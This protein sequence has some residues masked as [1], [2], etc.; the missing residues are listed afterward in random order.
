MICLQ[1]LLALHQRATEESNA[2]RQL[3]MLTLCETHPTIITNVALSSDYEMPFWEGPRS[4]ARTILKRFL[5][6]DAEATLQCLN[7]LCRG[8]RDLAR[9]FTS[10]SSAPSASSI[11]ACSPLPRGVVIHTKLWESVYDLLNSKHMDGI[12]LVLQ[13]VARIAHVD[14][15]RADADEGF[16][17][18][19][20]RADQGLRSRFVRCV[21]SV[22]DALGT[23][24]DSFGAH[25]ESFAE[26][27][28]ASL[29][30]EFLGRE[31]M[32]EEIIQLMLCPVDSLNGAAK[33]LAL[34][35]YDT[36][37]RST[38]Y[39][40][41]LEH[42]PAASFHGLI[43]YL[44]T[45][46]FYAAE[47]PEACGTSKYLVQSMTEI[48]SCLGD[49]ATG[50]LLNDDYGKSANLQLHACVPKL[51]KR[52]TDGLSIIFRLVKSWSTFCPYDEMVVWMR[53]ALIFGRDMI[54]VVEVLQS[55]T[56]R[57]FT[58]VT[59]GVDQ[60]PNLMADLSVILSELIEWLK[61]TDEETLHQSHELLKSLFARFASSNSEPPRSAIALL[62]RYAIR[63][64]GT[65]TQ[66]DDS[67]LAEL[68][69]TMEPFLDQDV[70]IIQPPPRKP[71]S[72]KAASPI[73][74]DDIEFLGTSD[75]ITRKK[76][77]QVDWEEVFPGMKGGKD[78][79]STVRDRMAHCNCQCH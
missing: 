5:I 52:M 37:E 57:A 36:V 20:L 1:A 33:V 49:S 29:L 65:R 8:R 56:D 7:E 50:L 10:R 42:H 35:A 64:K 59:S 45:F 25:L 16:S 71:I 14:D 48:L 26:L 27:T 28:G 69:V 32:T 61:L 78:S 15:L 67:K 17:S 63:A 31:G 77:Q 38:C 9:I 2:K 30:N 55:A 73:S 72:P 6:R 54:A 21:N 47:M 3:T 58:R 22:R 40:A 12:A 18:S 70:Q 79:K 68:M 53:D 13:A 41:F 39:K 62:E 46:N 44:T 76:V 51:W 74:D 75:M 4:A 23:I 19:F 43:S 11:Q 66:L 34:N 24:R 60:T